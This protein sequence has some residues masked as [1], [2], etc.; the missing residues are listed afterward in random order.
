MANTGQ[1]HSGGSQWFVVAGTQGES[2]PATYSLFGHVTS[3]LSVV[4]K[5]NAQGS[6]AG[7]PP[8]VT[9]RMLKVTITSS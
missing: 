7:V 5:I 4:E 9:H 6:A 8:D 1:P 2:L 3:G